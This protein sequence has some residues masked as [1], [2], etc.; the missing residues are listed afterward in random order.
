MP[1][2]FITAFEP[3]DQW[4]ENSSWLT[5]VEY[6]KRMER[7]ARVTTRLYPVD[8]QAVRHRLEMDLDADYDFALHLGQLPGAAS[9]HLESVAVNVGRESRGAADDFEPLVLDGPVAYRSALPL[10]PWADMLREAGIPAT[11]SYHAGTLLCNATMYLTHYFVEK[12]KLRTQTA[13]VHVPLDTEQAAHEQKELPALPARACA[14]ALR[15]IIAD[16]VKQE[17]SR[18]LKRA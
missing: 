13:F 3:Y 11:V 8:Y 2:I 17:R 5:L 1:S 6:T 10:G 14:S 15:M 4:A 18:G 7:E 12:K 16:L 9:I